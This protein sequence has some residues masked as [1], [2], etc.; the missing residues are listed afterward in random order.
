VPVASTDSC[1]SSHTVDILTS[2]GVI[3]QAQ[4]DVLSDTE[5]EAAGGGEVLLLELVLLDLQGAVQDLVG[6]EATDLQNGVMT[7]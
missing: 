4:I 5:A 6:L 7:R 2:S 1:N 3:L